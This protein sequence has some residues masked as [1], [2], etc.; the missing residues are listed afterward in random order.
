MKYSYIIILIF[1]LFSI[2]SF[3]QKEGQIFCEGD[4]SEPYF[5]LWQGKKNIIWQNTFYKEDFVGFKTI[6]NIEYLEYKQT[7]E[8]GDVSELYLRE[9]K[10][11]VFQ[12]E[13]CCEK[14]TMRMPKNPE[15]GMTWKTADK[16]ASYKIISLNTSL[17]T[18]VCNYK[19]LLQIK[20]ITSNI[21]FDF[22]Y[23]KGFGY[24]G[25]K[26]NKELISFVVPKNL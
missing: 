17:D 12:Y 7:W 3:S 4:K 20:L 11:I 8:N 1:T 26:V 9:E 24:V 19:N 2:K 5:M 10:G 23:L 25:A 18:K 15:V 6:N 14:E 22:Y 16:L 21:V 13:S